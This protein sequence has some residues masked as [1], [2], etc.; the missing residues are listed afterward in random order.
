MSE[1]AEGYAVGQG[2][3]NYGGGCFGG[4][5]GD[6]IAIIV[7]FALFANGGWGGAGYGG[8]NNLGYELGRV[9]TTNDVAS[10]FNNS[11]V[12]GNLNDLKL[13]QSGLQN[14]L[15]QNFS[16]IKY[17]IASES[18]DIKRAISDAENRI[19]DRMNQRETQELRDK[20]Q[21]YQM[22]ELGLGF[23]RDVTDE[24]VPRARPAYITCNPN[25][26]FGSWGW[27]PAGNCGYNSCGFNCA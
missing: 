8:G 1:F 25:L 11:A 24:V 3:N 16:D 21:Y 19:V 7:L 13:G 18:C 10:G 17:G 5:G 26:P 6:W 27:N 12:L 9:A 4:M 23:V 14:T 20:V 2:N 22:R 15:C